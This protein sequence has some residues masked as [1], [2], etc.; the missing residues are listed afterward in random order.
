MLATCLLCQAK[1]LKRAMLQADDGLTENT[2][3]T[4][5]IQADKRCNLLPDANATDACGN[6]YQTL[7]VALLALETK[8]C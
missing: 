3:D 4:S 6:A 7:T 1:P 5:L 8:N 2:T